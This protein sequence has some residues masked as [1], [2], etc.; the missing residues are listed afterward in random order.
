MA[1]LIP[2]GT[3]IPNKKP[4]VQEIKFPFT[5]SSIRVFVPGLLLA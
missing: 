3:I 2:N 5:G 1:V 4:V